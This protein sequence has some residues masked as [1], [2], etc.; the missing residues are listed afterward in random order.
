MPTQSGAF[1]AEP[2]PPTTGPGRAVAVQH[3]LSAGVAL[4]CLRVGTFAKT[5]IFTRREASTKTVVFRTD[6]SP[7][8][9]MMA[10]SPAPGRAANYLHSHSASGA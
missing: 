2:P 9:K 3:Q 8:S 10:D 6:S 7:A 5:R 1:H 4:T